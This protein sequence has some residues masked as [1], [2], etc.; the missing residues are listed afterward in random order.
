M[1]IG[2][3]AAVLGAGIAARKVR[4]SEKR[5]RLI[6]LAGVLGTAMGFGFDLLLE[7]DEEEPIFAIAGAGSL[8]GLALGA[9]LTRTYDLGKDLATAEVT[10]VGPGAPRTP[11]TTL[12][13]PLLSVRKLAVAEGRPVPTL[14]VRVDF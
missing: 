6:N 2:S 1:L 11:R 8:A 9:S 5:M 7:V 4:L 12:R 10:A 13:A 14:S 3:D